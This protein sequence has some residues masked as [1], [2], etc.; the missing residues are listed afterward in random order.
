MRKLL[1]STVALAALMTTPIAMADPNDNPKQHDSTKPDRG[2]NDRG[3]G[4]NGGA[5]SGPGTM[6][7]PSGGNANADRDKANDRNDDNDRANNR[8][9]DKTVIHNNSD[10]TV[11]H[12][13]SRTVNKTVVHKTVDRSVVL[14]VRANIRAP[15]RF[16]APRAYIRPAGWYAH[17]W[18][19]GERLPRAFFAPG[20]FILDFAAF[21]LLAPWDGYEWVRYGDDALLIDVETGEVIRVEYDVF[22]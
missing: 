3:N 22:Y 13:N 15:H 2:D 19:Y 8:D 9:N 18:V 1:F 10:R 5:M 16:R 14:K 7:S 6:G 20:Y 21:G 4:P 11:I 12:D 17:R